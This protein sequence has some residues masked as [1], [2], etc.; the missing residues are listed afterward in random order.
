MALID[1]DLTNPRGTDQ[2]THF[3]QVP[4][5][6]DGRVGRPRGRVFHNAR[7][8]ERPSEIHEMDHSAQKVI[9]KLNLSRLFAT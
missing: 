2:P 9:S 1:I 3:R 4:A 7:D 6:R 5:R 8:V